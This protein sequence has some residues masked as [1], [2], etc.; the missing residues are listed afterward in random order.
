MCKK[1]N[2]F[3]CLVLTIKILFFS[4]SLFYRR[5]II[6]F[7]LIL[8]G[9]VSLNCQT[10]PPPLFPSLSGRVSEPACFGAAPAPAPEDIV[11]LHIFEVL[12]YILNN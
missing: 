11:F 4:L 7:N 8:F 9:I 6:R 2:I 3:N 10:F 12:K 1:E 5:Q